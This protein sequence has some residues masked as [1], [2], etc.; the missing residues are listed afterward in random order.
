MATAAA[1]LTCCHSLRADP[2]IPPDWRRAISL[3]RRF[4]GLC[5]GCAAVTGG[6]QGGDASPCNDSEVPRGAKKGFRLIYMRRSRCCDL[7]AALSCNALRLLRFREAV[8]EPALGEVDPR[9]EFRLRI[10]TSGRSMVGD[11]VP[12]AGK[13]PAATGELVPNRMTAS[14]PAGP[15]TRTSGVE[16]TA[17]PFLLPRADAWTDPDAG[18]SS[19]KGADVSA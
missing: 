9:L 18:L 17:R 5:A 19:S 3:R 1:R 14:A 2:D 8:C 13:L 16:P 7:W 6:V 12:E 11:D 15:R 10:L 4:G